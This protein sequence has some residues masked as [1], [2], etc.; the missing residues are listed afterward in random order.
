MRAIDVIVRFGGDE[1]GVLLT[2]T[3][4]EA[5]L[6]VSQKLVE[7]LLGLVQRNGWQVTFSIGVASFLYPPD[8]ISEMIEMA[9]A[10]MYIAKQKGKNRIQQKTIT[11]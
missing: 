5:S 10:Q 7:K 9:D 6:Q 4:A 3:D 2:E 11:D 8:N 1:F